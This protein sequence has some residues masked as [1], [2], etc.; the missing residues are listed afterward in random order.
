MLGSLRMYHI[1]TGD[2]RT[3]DYTPLHLQDDSPQPKSPLAALRVG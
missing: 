1:R 2:K 3:R